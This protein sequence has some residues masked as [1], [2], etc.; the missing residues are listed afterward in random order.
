MKERLLAL[1]PPEIPK[2]AK[3][4]LGIEILLLVAAFA[5]PM[6][7]QS[8]P[9]IVPSSLGAAAGPV[10]WTSPGITLVGEGDTLA[11]ERAIRFDLNEAY[12]EDFD[13]INGI[14]TKTAQAIYD[15][16]IANGPYRDFADL[17]RVPGLHASAIKAMLPYVRIGDILGEGAPLEANLKG[18]AVVNVNVAT[19]EELQL[20]NGVGEAMANDIMSARPFAS[21]QDMDDRVKGLGPAKL[22]KMKPFIAFSG[23]N[24]TPM[25][26]SAA[27]AGEKV[28]LN[29]ATAEQLENLPGM[30][31]TMC[32]ALVAYRAEHG[33]FQHIEDLK[34]IKR[35]GE[36]RI[37]KIR[38]F[39]TIGGVAP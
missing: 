38:P 21:L 1:V 23:A 22:E 19:L 15:F 9:S 34:N 18:K 16:R 3:I 39:V 12:P 20:I 11:M 36:A 25:A 6:V 8:A 4:G 37:E 28:E 27:G 31:P 26:G 7:A 30:G 14:G 33:P 13:R 35:F 17:E 2:W 10:S 32:A 5:V 29:T 24:V